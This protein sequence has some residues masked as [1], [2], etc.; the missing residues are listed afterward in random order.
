VDIKEG[1]MV[2]SSDD[3][4]LQLLKI[5]LTGS[6]YEE[7][8]W[9]YAR[10]PARSEITLKHP[11]R[12]VRAFIQKGI[13]T[14]AKEI[15]I[16][17]LRRGPADETA[18]EQGKDWP[19]VGL[20]MVGFK[21]LDN[22]EE[23]VRRV[24]ETKIPGD[25]VECGVWKGGSAIFMKAVADR[26]GLV[27]RN[28][29]LADSFEGM[30]KPIM[31]EDLTSP[32]YDLSATDQ[33]RS[34]PEQVLKSFQ[35]LG[36]YDERVRILKGWFKDTLPFAPIEQ[37]AILRLDG[38]LYE[39]TRDALQSLY[40]KVSPGGFV[41]VDDYSSWAPCQKAVDEFRKGRNIESPIKRI[42]WTGVYWK[43]V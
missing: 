28:V 6:L 29:W 15:G 40:H 22:I 26:L 1:C 34:S 37:I 25:F 32:D 43:V 12:A 19:F 24:A 3:K 30:P 2:I 11:G 33:L 42:D 13:L 17:I 14:F 38:D 18:R 8:Y 7:S 23:C 41:I 31:A 9:R 35:H 21:R 36:L 10:M 20:T 39:S 4:Y 5:T 16:E 27:D